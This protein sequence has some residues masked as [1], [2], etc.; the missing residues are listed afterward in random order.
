LETNFGWKCPRRSKKKTE[1]YEHL[2]YKELQ[3]ECKDV[4]LSAKGKT[5]ELRTRLKQFNQK[6]LSI[7]KK[8]SKKEEKSTTK[9]SP[10]SKPTIDEKQGTT[11]KEEL[12]C[13]LCLELLTLPVETDCGHAYCAACFVTFFEE[14]KKQQEED[15][16]WG[17]ENDS[18]KCPTCRTKVKTVLSSIA[19]R[20]V[21]SVLQAS[22]AKTDKKTQE[23]DSKISDINKSLQ[24]SGSSGSSSRGFILLPPTFSLLATQ[25]LL[26]MQRPSVTSGSDEESSNSSESYCEDCGEV[27]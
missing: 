24:E 22:S 25:F 15:I 11:L 17:V 20:K 3:K 19:L 14:W 5:E 23:L 4:G 21:I 7:K 1:D 2:N 10:R 9:N 26:G 13:P 16:S 18:P 12:C 6:S 8:I 27:H